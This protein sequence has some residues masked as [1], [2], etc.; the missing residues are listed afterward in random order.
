MQPKGEEHMD[1]LSKFKE[2]GI[3]L[4]SGIKRLSEREKRKNLWT[5]DDD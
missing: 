5:S 1:N 3:L 4:Y 2:I